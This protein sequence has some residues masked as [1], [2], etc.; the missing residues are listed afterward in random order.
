MSK[1]L[2]YSRILSKITVDEQI[3]CEDLLK[4][5][6]TPHSTLQARRAK[7]RAQIIID[8]VYENFSQKIR[9]GRGAPVVWME[10][11]L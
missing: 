8:R 1:I 5:S 9:T 6:N 7:N 11:S 4:G 2:I 3:Q 10:L